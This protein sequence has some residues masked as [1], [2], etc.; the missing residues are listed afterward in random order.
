VMAMVVD[1]MGQKRGCTGSPQLEKRCGFRSH[2]VHRVAILCYKLSASLRAWF[3]F[4]L[5]VACQFYMAVADSG[6]LVMRRIRNNFLWASGARFSG[7]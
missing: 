6:G 5:L 2:L 7:I 1:T 3:S 4:S